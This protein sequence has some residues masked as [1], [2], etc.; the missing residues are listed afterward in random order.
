MKVWDVFTDHEAV[1]LVKDL[2]AQEGSD[3]LVKQSLERG[4]MDN[5]TAIVVKFIPI[6]AESTESTESSQ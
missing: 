3:A 4:S 2:G 5:I 6:T 1:D